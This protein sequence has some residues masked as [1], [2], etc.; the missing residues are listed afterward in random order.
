MASIKTKILT[1]RTD[2]QFTIRTAQSE[3]A[4]AILAYIRPVAEETEFFVIEPD[5]FPHTVEEEQVWIQ[6][7]VD[8]PGKILLLAEA[9][10]TIIG[11][12]TFEAGTFRRIAHRG[13]LGI[14]IADK[15]RGRGIGMALLQS[16]LDWATASPD[17]EKVCLDT[18]ASNLRAIGL[19]RKLG[20]TEEGR[21][22]K[23]I[24]RGSDEY[25]DTISM[26]RFVK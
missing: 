24:K 23:D 16:L 11:S 10:G 22:I 14:S 21:R 12:V 19:Y 20:F 15:W 25:I 9:N 8:H 1:D 3:D 7:H 17:I 6:D 13:S 18:F 2:E 4:E 5:E 26:Y